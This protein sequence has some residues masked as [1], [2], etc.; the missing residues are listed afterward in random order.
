MDFDGSDDLDINE[1][2]EVWYKFLFL[3]NKIEFQY[4]CIEGVILFLVSDSNIMIGSN[5]L[6][7]DKLLNYD[8]V[9]NLCLYLQNVLILYMQLISTFSCIFFY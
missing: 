4:I 9:N 8:T 1:F 2:F 6:D 5:D 3:Y 7:V